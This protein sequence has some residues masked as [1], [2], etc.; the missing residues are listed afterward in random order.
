ME[1][2]QF[3]E[4]NFVVR[5]AYDNNKLMLNTVFFSSHLMILMISNH[6]FPRIATKPSKV[7]KGS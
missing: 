3:L 2:F 4:E 6:L 5:D 1:L 7:L